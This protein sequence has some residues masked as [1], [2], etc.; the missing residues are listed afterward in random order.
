MSVSQRIDELTTEGTLDVRAVA[1]NV[2]QRERSGSFGRSE[3]ETRNCVFQGTNVSWITWLRVYNGFQYA[4]CVFCMRQNTHR[5]TQAYADHPRWAE[6]VEQISGE[7]CGAFCGGFLIR[8]Q[9]VIF[10]GEQ[11]GGHIKIRCT[12]TPPHTSLST[13]NKSIQYIKRRCT[14]TPPVPKLSTVN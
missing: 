13:F 1:V 5:K 12:M 6:N 4:S 11:V 8:K 7:I 9:N 14:K 2:A 3:L 10:F